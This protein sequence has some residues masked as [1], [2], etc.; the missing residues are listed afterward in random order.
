MLEAVG[1]LLDLME[2]RTRVLPPWEPPWRP[3]WPRRRLRPVWRH[4]LTGGSWLSEWRSREAAGHLSTAFR[5]PG[6]IE[7]GLRW[8]R[9]HRA[10]RLLAGCLD[11]RLGIG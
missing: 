6:S 4:P 2:E 5:S 9:R 1:A 8:T 11:P 3:S 10:L 7:P